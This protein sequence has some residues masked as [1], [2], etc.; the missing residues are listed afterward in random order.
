VLPTSLASLAL[1]ERR[2][3]MSDPVPTVTEAGATGQIA[4]IFADIR[5]VYHVGVVNLI[6]RHLAT[7]PG[8]LPWVWESVRP[9]YVDGTIERE[10]AAL[11]ASIALPDLPGFPAAAFAA[12]GLS[13]RDI[14]QIREV[15]AAY[16]RT[17]AMALIA[18][19]AVD[20]KIAGT[21]GE[22][23]GAFAGRTEVPASSQ[24]ELKL[25]P[26]LNLAEM[27]PEAAKLVVT[28]NRLGAQRDDSILASMYR[29]LAHW[30]PYLALA[31]MMIA[32]LD[33]DTRLDDTISDTL[34]KAR[35]SGRRLV[36]RLPTPSLTV[37]SAVRA[38]IS[39]ALDCFT[40][41]VIA[42]MVVIGALLRRATGAKYD[43]E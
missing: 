34:A 24:A 1:S 39:R 3:T 13:E 43:G 40:N 38:D 23:D 22:A 8:A 35:E 41:D 19:S 36:R 25:P 2:K 18:L 29:H 30:P 4:D 27:S 5:H 32:P 7:F 31:W 10:A 21:Q 20:C 37:A 6:W 11:R 15:L 17:N 26:L 9:L 42:K 33:A 16:D 28:M 12:V 14:E